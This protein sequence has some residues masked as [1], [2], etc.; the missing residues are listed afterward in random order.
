[1]LIGKVKLAV[2]PSEHISEVLLHVIVF[3]KKHL[4][5]GLIR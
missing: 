2:K 1:M 4:S 5:L 3:Y